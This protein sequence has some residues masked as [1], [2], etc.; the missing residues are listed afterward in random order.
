MSTRLAIAADAQFPIDRL[1]LGRS[2]S[3]VFVNAR[4]YVFGRGLPVTDGRLPDAGWL[5]GVAV[6]SSRGLHAG[7]RWLIGVVLSQGSTAH[8]ERCNNG[9]SHCD[10]THGHH[11]FLL[12]VVFNVRRSDEY[13]SRVARGSAWER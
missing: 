5:P 8:G 7:T 2:H 13:H 1:V 11:L 3:Q 10:S 4:R 12:N 6:C 9:I